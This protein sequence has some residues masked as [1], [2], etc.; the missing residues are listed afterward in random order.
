[1][2]SSSSNNYTN[3]KPVPRP[4]YLDIP[5]AAYLGD[6]IEAYEK[7]I[8]TIANQKLHECAKVKGGSSSSST[9]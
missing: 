6:W 1:M 5:I 3:D 7:S 9:K 2:E 4:L 8:Q